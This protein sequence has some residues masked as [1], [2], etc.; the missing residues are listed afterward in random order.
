MIA[1]G[2]PPPILVADGRGRDRDALSGDVL[3]DIDLV[4]ERTTGEDLE[5]VERGLER[6]VGP[7]GHHRVHRGHRDS[8]H[9]VLR[10][11]AARVADAPHV[12]NGRFYPARRSAARSTGGGAAGDSGARSKAGTKEYAGQGPVGTTATPTAREAT[13]AMRARKSASSPR[14]SRNATD[15]TTLPAV[16]AG[17]FRHCASAARSTIWSASSRRRRSSA[18]S[19]VASTGAA[20][21]GA[22]SSRSSLTLISTQPRT[23]ASAPS[24]ADRSRVSQPSTSAASSAVPYRKGTSPSASSAEATTS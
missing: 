8:R 19:R 5:D 21:A 24:S 2:S 6:A 3:Q 1:I 4:R 11:V 20:A 10:E 9:A 16:P 23:L 18:A 13:G 17:R 15:A 22:V 14:G 12:C 7:L